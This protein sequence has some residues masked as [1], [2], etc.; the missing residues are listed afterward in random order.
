[1]FDAAA[2]ETAKRLESLGWERIVIVSETR[3]AARFRD[4]LPPLVGDRVIAES[5]LNLVGEDQHVIA[6]TLESLIEDA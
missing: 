6:E 1:L 4:A 5:D 3:A 2:A